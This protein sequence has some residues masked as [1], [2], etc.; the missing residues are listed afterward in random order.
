M[1]DEPPTAFPVRSGDEVPALK[2]LPRQGGFEA[3]INM[4]IF[5]GRT[6]YKWRSF[7]GFSVDCPEGSRGCTEA[8]VYVG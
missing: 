1:F 8:D 4:E 5:G 7:H 2:A 3:V 6:I